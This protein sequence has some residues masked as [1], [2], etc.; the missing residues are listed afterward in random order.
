M[1]QHQQ[2]TIQTH[3]G[4][5]PKCVSISN[6][7]LKHIQTV[8]SRQS[9]NVSASATHDPNTS[10]QSLD[11]SA[12]ATCDSNTPV[13]KTLMLNAHNAVTMRWSRSFLVQVKKCPAQSKTSKPLRV[14]DSESRVRQVGYVW[15]LSC[16]CFWGCC[17]LGKLSSNIF[18][19]TLSSK[20]KRKEYS[21]EAK[22]NFHDSM[23]TVVFT[24]WYILICPRRKWKKNP[25]HHIM[26]KVI[27]SRHIHIKK[28]LF[29][30]KWFFF[31][32]NSAYQ[33]IP[34]L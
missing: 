32:F 31:H 7:R 14:T 28:Y 26:E 23:W 29:I 4:R 21:K 3:S 16:F 33:S 5:V 25:S 19:V 18:I 1:C 15:V 11:E 12:S 27:L 30:L 10:R 13:P 17:F 9:L 6:T 8:T 2:H 20:S 24:F 22:T 34:F